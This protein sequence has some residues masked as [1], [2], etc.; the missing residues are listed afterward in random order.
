MKAKNKYHKPSN[1][2]SKI[3][4]GLFVVI[5]GCIFLADQSGA[6]VPDGLLSWETFLIAFGFVTLLRHYFRHFVGY[7]MV[8]VGTAFLLDDYYPQLIDT[9][10]I[11][12][13][14]VILFGIVMIAK[15]TNL[16]GSKKKGSRSHVM[17]DEDNEITGDDFIEATAL[18]GAVKKN[19]TSKNFRGAD[20]S[21]MFGGTEINLSK[22]DIQEPIKI[23]SRTAFGGITL[24][25]PSNWQ[26]RSDVTA[27]FGAVE[28]QRPIQGDN[29]IDESKIVIL[30]GTCIFGGVEIQSYA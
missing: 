8:G 14:A 6:N 5:F 7:A 3:V 29:E 18:F 1:K 17:F 22:A 26:V 2:A 28:D 20:I 27:I 15:A 24:I 10:L 16:F 30:E 21:T 4:A 9:K 11:L 19:V 13:V 25:V 23:N 12:P